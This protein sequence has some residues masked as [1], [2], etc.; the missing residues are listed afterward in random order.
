MIKTLL[1]GSITLFSAYIIYRRYIEVKMMLLV[2]I[3]WVAYIS[4]SGIMIYKQYLSGEIYYN[5][6]DFLLWMLVHQIL[7][8][9]HLLLFKQ[10]RLINT[11]F[12]K[13]L[14]LFIIILNL[15]LILLLDI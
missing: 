1:I 3:M 12:Q 14:Y 4:S 11:E 7:L 5:H 8:S 15:V 13:K 10:T 2:G 6:I 9:I